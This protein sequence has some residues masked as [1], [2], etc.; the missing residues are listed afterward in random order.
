M[1]KNM[2][3]FEFR[4]KHDNAISEKEALTELE[5]YVRAADRALDVNLLCAAEY[6][7]DYK[8]YEKLRKAACLVREAMNEIYDKNNDK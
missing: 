6:V 4:L 5:L 2:H 7:A 1:K 3:N 8:T